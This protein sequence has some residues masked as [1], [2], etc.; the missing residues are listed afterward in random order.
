MRRKAL[1][2]GLPGEEEQGEEEGK[3]EERGKKDE[4]GE[5]PHS[6]RSKNYVTS[7]LWRLY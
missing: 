2:G 1:A 4:G 7:S 6:C 3:K 5:I